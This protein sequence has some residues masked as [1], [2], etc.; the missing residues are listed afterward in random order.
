MTNKQITQI[1]DGDGKGAFDI[2][3][4]ILA[5]KREMGVAFVEL[6]RLLKKVRDEGY[7]QVLGYDSFQSYVVNS[8][9]GFRTRTAYY[10]IEIYKWF[11][12]KLGFTPDYIGTIGQDK[13]LRVLE[14]L[15]K[16]FDE[17]EKYP[18]PQLKERAENLMNEAGELRPVD[19]DKKYKDEEKQKGHTNYLAPPE[20][21]RCS[22]HGKWRIVIPLDDCCPKWLLEIKKKK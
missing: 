22:C 6:G 16:E 1:T 18:L 10:Y 5:L 2:H 9:L 17:S 13:L 12:S 3:Q 19:F 14:I 8:E 20:Y 21:F 11:V 7:F 4:T 15:K